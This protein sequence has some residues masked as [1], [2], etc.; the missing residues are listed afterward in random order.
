MAGENPGS[1]L[2]KAKKIKDHNPD[3]TMILISHDF[4]FL[5]HL[6]DKYMVM[7]GGF[8]IETIR[9]KNQ[10]KNL[11]NLHPY[12]SELLSKLRGDDAELKNSR[13]RYTTYLKEQIR[14]WN[15]ESK[16]NIDKTKKSIYQHHSDMFKEKLHNYNEGDE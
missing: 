12:T 15:S 14:Y 5:H 13:A 2:S 9:D 10:M 3:L 6:V 7:L 1:K 8:L 4:G 11:E 16:K